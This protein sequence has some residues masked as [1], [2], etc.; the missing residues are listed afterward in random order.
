MIKVPFAIAFGWCKKAFLDV[1]ADR[2]RGNTMMSGE[3][4]DIHERI[5]PRVFEWC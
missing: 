4:T 3:I 2:H 1:V 5:I